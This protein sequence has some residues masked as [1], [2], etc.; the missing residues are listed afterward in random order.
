MRAVIEERVRAWREGKNLQAMLA[1]LH[2]I[3]PAAS[4]WQP[5]SLAALV[6]QQSVHDAYKA[7]LLSV[8]PDK[9]LELKQPEH[10]QERGQLVFAALRREWTQYKKAFRA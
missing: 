4:G 6:D 7:S 8:H 1:T 9:L 5:L 10:V 2:E 3:A